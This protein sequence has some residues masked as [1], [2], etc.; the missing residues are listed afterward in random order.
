MRRLAATCRRLS[1]Q[2]SHVDDGEG[3]HHPVADDADVADL[4]VSAENA[5][6][7]AGKAQDGAGCHT[8]ADADAALHATG[9]E[10]CHRQQERQPGEVVPGEDVDRVRN[11]GPVPGEEPV[12]PGMCAAGSRPTVKTVTW[13]PIVM[14][15]MATAMPS[16]ANV[17]SD[18]ARWV[19]RSGGGWR[20][21]PRSVAPAP[22]S[23]AS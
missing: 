13:T 19:E 12:K 6:Q 15:A 3:E 20:T 14:A 23:T 10:R 11:G 21:A 2:T 1:E 8:D 9:R 4:H 7:P 17:R 5:K 22:R 18:S 16:P